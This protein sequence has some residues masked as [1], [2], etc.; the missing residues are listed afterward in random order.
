MRIPQSSRAL[1][2]V[3]VTA[4]IAIPSVIIVP[5]LHVLHVSPRTDLDVSG[6]KRKVLILGAS[7]T[8]ISPTQHPAG[9]TSWWWCF[10]RSC[11]GWPCAAPPSPLLGVL[12]PIPFGVGVICDPSLFFS[13]RVN[14][15]HKCP[16]A[17]HTFQRWGA[18]LRPSVTV[19]SMTLGSTTTQYA[20]SR[21]R[22]Q[23]WPAD[24]GTMQRDMWG[25]G[26]SAVSVDFG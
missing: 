3:V 7:I 20:H 9:A 10:W 22:S 19:P 23:A 2:V 26:R 1:Y 13:Q 18:G 24:H 6:W 21:L 4:H 25:F 12:R 5:S 14:T 11:S 8:F 15:V 17:E 16:L